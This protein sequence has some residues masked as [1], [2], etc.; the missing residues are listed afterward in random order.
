MCGL[1]R[2]KVLKV[3]NQRHYSSISATRQGFR[4]FKTTKEPW[5]I[6]PTA[7]TSTSC[8]LLSLRPAH[9]QINFFSL[10]YES[11]EQTDSQSHQSIRQS[12]ASPS[13]GTLVRQSHQPVWY[14]PVTTITQQSVNHVTVSLFSTSKSIAL[15]SQ[16]VYCSQPTIPVS[17]SLELSISPSLPLKPSIQSTLTYNSSLS[18]V[19]PSQKNSVNATS[20]WCP[21]AMRPGCIWLSFWHSSIRHSLCVLWAHD[22]SI[23]CLVT[24]VMQIAHQ[25]RRFGEELYFA[26]T[27]ACQFLNYL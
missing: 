22:H 17:A 10:S 12:T 23:V 5:L 15:V 7:I 14:Q 20:I 4:W 26:F 18:R 11:G 1:F 24:H 8:L 3:P 9:E 2:P 13:V 27:K 25:R 16:S 21:T 6:V 19:S